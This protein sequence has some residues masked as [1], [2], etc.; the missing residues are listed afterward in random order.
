MN[1]IK[2]IA[3]LSLVVSASCNSGNAAKDAVEAKKRQDSLLEEFKKVNQKIG[4]ARTHSDSVRLWLDSISKKSDT[5]SS[6]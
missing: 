3:G 4:E 5:I 2:I 1:P 6:H